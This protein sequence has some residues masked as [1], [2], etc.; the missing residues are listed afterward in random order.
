MFVKIYGCRGSI[1]VANRTTHKYGGNTT[2]LYVESRAGDAIII[3]AGSGIRELGGYLVQNRKAVLHL[4]LTHYHWDHLQGFP[5]F[6]PVYLKSTK[7]NI[8]GAHKEASPKDALSYQMSFPY[9]PTI[10]L[11]NLPAQ[12][13]YRELKKVLNIGPV[14]IQTME[15]NHP[16]YTK[17][18]RFTEGGK[19]LVFMTDNELFYPKN[20]AKYRSFV[21]FARGAE[22]LIHDAAYSDEIY[23]KKIGW[24]HSTYSQVMQLANDSGVKHVVFTHHDPPTSDAFISDIVKMY[25]KAHPRFNIEAAADG[26]TFKF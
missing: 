21:N 25:R 14:R 23:P 20:K 19:S 22:V 18:L 15:M 26:K 8:Y 5:F 11:A 13:K 17:G 4:I 12:F 7:I 10:T 1:P 3:D 6:V 24:G 16:N 9:F 2:C